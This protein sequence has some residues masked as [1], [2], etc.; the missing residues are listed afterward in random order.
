MKA[1]VPSL[2]LHINDPDLAD[3][4]FPTLLRR[5]PLNNAVVPLPPCRYC[6]CFGVNYCDYEYYVAPVIG[7][8]T[9]WE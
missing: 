9:H 4:D 7:G 1:A 8:N 3:F 2:L 6:H 5:T